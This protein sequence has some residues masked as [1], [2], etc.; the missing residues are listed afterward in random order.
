MTT[1]R[2]YHVAAAWID[3]NRE[4]YY[5]TYDCEQSSAYDAKSPSHCTL[6]I[7]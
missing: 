1:I 4:A 7:L 3:W 6:L 5:V 2:V